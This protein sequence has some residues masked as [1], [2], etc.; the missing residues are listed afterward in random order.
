MTHDAILHLLRERDALVVWRID[1]VADRLRRLHLRHP[2]HHPDRGT[3]MTLSEDIATALTNLDAAADHVESLITAAN[4]LAAQLQA[5]IDQLNATAGEGLTGAQ[6]EAALMHLSAAV[7]RLNQMGSGT[8][9]PP[10]APT[11]APIPTP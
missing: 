10:P 3:A 5:T 2:S 4:A 6:T 11:P 7:T 8:P 1:R 9:I